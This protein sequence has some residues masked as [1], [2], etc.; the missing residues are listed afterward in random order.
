MK[1]IICLLPCL[2][3]GLSLLAQPITPTAISGAPLTLNTNSICGTSS[4]SPELSQAILKSIQ[5]F[6]A[7]TPSLRTTAEPVYVA[8]KFHSVISSTN[9]GNARNLTGQFISDLNAA[10]YSTGIQF[11]QQ[12]G[13]N[14]IEKGGRF[15]NFNLENEESEL[16]DNIDVGNAINVY[17]VNSFIGNPQVKGYVRLPTSANELIHPSNNNYSLS[18]KRFNR[19]FIAMNFLNNGL[20]IDYNYFTRLTKYVLPHEMGHY[21]G[22]LHTFD[23]TYNQVNGG[24][25]GDCNRTGDLICDTPP[26]LM[27]GINFTDASAC[28]NPWNLLD[29]GNILYPPYNNLMSYSYGCGNVFTPMQR[30]RMRNWGYYLRIKDSYTNDNLE[31]RYYIDGYPHIGYKA[32]S[33]NVCAG[34][35]VRFKLVHFGDWTTQELRRLQVEISGPGVPRQMLVTTL[36]D[37]YMVEATIPVGAQ[38]GTHDIRV[39]DPSPR[40]Y[41]Y[42]PIDKIQ[43]NQQPPK[44]TFTGLS[45][46]YCQNDEAIV[47]TATPLGGTFTLD[48]NTTSQLNPAS[49]SAGS[50]TVSYTVLGNGCTNTIQQNVQVKASPRKPTISL[51]T[52]GLVSSAPQGNQWYVDGTALFGQTSPKLTATQPGSIQ[53]GVNVNG[54]TALSD[55]FVITGAHQE[56]GSL[57]IIAYPNPATESVWISGVSGLIHVKAISLSGIILDEMQYESQGRP[58]EF[59]IRDSFGQQFIL[60]VDSEGRTWS[61]SIIIESN[62]E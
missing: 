55:A 9:A 57:A 39:T 2:L 11:F 56:P 51:Q 41:Y 48:G 37:D 30:E 1:R 5:T 38:T 27:E 7:Q 24:L 17:L 60:K 6:E 21:F 59:P 8:V 61:K 10:F 32:T 54:C 58:I 4:P 14:L 36:I 3:L 50:H 29:D 53:V 45:A 34:Q 22:L 33:N 13:V 47:L 44:P 49:L 40:V 20:Q 26:T 42:Q 52:D 28:N 19:V 15:F 62:K 43:I 16:C 23:K 35:K 18:E 46:A 31:T 12:G 25:Y